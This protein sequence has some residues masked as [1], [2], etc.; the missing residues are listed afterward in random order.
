MITTAINA[1]AAEYGYRPSGHALPIL[2]YER[3]TDADHDRMIMVNIVIA[4][5]KSFA[6]ATLGIPGVRHPDPVVAVHALMAL[7][8]IARVEVTP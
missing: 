2:F 5:D 4:G 8:G 7:C 6:D 1:A 3:P